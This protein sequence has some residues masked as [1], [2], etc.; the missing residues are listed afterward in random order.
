MSFVLRNSQEETKKSLKKIHML[1]AQ[2][3]RLTTKKY[4]GIP[5]KKRRRLQTLG[6]NG[7]EGPQVQFPGEVRTKRRPIRTKLTLKLLQDQF[8]IQGSNQELVISIK[9]GLC[10]SLQLH[11][12]QIYKRKK[13]KTKILVNKEPVASNVQL[14]TYVV[15]V[16]QE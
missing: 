1:N 15:S 5:K 4:S 10:N 3:K 2:Q 8:R 7:K 6:G 12:I 13:K 14:L 16:L 11:I 9:F